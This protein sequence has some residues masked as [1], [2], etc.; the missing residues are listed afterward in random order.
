MHKLKLGIAT[1]AAIGVTGATLAAT[2]A[3][4]KPRTPRPGAHPCTLGNRNGVPVSVPDG[5]EVTVTFM[6]R[7]EQVTVTYRCD[8]GNWVSAHESLPT[9]TIPARA[10]FVVMSVGGRINVSQLHRVNAGRAIGS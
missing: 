8:N 9:L 3:F 6:Q 5:A 7:G 1:V 4:A 2:P 10:T